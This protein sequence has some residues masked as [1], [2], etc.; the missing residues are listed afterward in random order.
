ME[1]G[2]EWNMERNGMQQYIKCL[3][4]AKLTAN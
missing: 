3:I 1:Y 2:M 4:S